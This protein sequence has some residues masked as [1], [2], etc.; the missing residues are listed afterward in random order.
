[1]TRRYCQRVPATTQTSATAVTRWWREETPP[2]NL[3]QIVVENARRTPDRVVINRREGTTWTP[4]TAAGFAAE[5]DRL[6][7]GFVAAGVAPG[8]R[9]GLMC[10][11]RYEWTLVDFALWTAGAVTVPV[12]E[13]SSPSSCAGSWPTPARVGC[14]VETPRARRVSSPASRPAARAARHL[15]IDGGT[16]ASPTLVAGGAASD[17]ELDRRRAAADPATLATII[18][19]S[20]TTGRPKGCELTHGNFLRRGL[21]RDRLPARAVRGGTRRRCC[22]CRSRTCSAG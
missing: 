18:Y 2:A 20:G 22:S 16:G 11:T 21:Q 5:V 13:T 19:T 7:L 12:Y 4:V 3:A 8:D 15:A 1:M 10:R 9:V 6:A 17:A 14:F